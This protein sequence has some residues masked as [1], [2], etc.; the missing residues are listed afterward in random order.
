MDGSAFPVIPCSVERATLSGGERARV[1]LAMIMLSGANL[2]IFDEPTNHLDVESIEALEDAVAEFGGTVILVSHDRT[3]LRALTTRT[4]ILHDGRIT[5][6]PGGFEE[7]ETVS[8]ERAHAASVAA[9]EAEALRRVKERKQTRR[10]GKDRRGVES[11]L[12]SAEREVA[13]AELEV[14]ECEARVEA[15][16]AR[17][18]NPDLYMTAEGAIQAGSIGR[19]LETAKGELERAFDRWET[20]TR[21]MK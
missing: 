20:A 2:L 8:A 13:L 7:W 21:Q 3:L 11:E 19:E 9:A 16:R 4:W 6:F 1:A 10:Q 17:L 15:L 12:R 5:D 18:E 14:A